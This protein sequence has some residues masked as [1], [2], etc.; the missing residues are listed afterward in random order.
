MTETV[1]AAASPV[2]CSVGSVQHSNAKEQFVRT[3]PPPSGRET[4]SAGPGRG[5]ME[6]ECLATLR[7]HTDGVTEVRH[8]L[9]LNPIAAS[10][11][12]DISLSDDDG[13]STICCLPC[14]SMFHQSG[15]QQGS[16]CII[17][18]GGSRT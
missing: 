3:P 18:S 14:S 13:V 15:R 8:A 12:M 4:P 1:H 6:L 9:T 7:G 5:L 11:R 10:E 2:K 16:N 17:C